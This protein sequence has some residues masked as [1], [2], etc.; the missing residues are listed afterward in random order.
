MIRSRFIC[1]IY[2]YHLQFCTT[3]KLPS[4]LRSRVFITRTFAI[5]PR[6]RPI[7]AKT[8]SW[9]YGPGKWAARTLDMPVV[10]VT[11]PLPSLLGCRR[12]RNHCSVGSLLAG[13]TGHGV[14]VWDP[15]SMLTR[16]SH[17]NWINGPIAIIGSDG[18]WICLTSFISV[19]CA[20]LAVYAGVNWR[21]SQSNLWP[22]SSSVTSAGHRDW[23]KRRFHMR[24][25]ISRTRSYVEPLPLKWPFYLLV[26]LDAQ[27]NAT[28]AAQALWKRRFILYSLHPVTRLL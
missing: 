17:V 28:R 23:V 8:V 19:M 4:H 3:T 14:L 16:C 18:Q 11:S 7:F 21:H 1:V 25:V 22:S 26:S 27:R 2:A 10:F 13:Q 24:Y 9:T 5:C 6:R 12:K 20:Y 15:W